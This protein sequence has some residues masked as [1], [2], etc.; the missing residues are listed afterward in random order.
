MKVFVNYKFLVLLGLFVMAL[1]SCDDE[2]TDLNI[3]PN[4]PVEVPAANL[5]TQAEYSLVN[6]L[7]G[8]GLN[9]E[10]SMLMVQHFAQTEYAEES[11]YTVDAN[12]FN[13]EWTTFYASV[14]NELKIASEII[15]ADA[16]VPPARKSNQLAIVDVLT[17]YAYHNLTD[18]Y[19]AAPF[20]EALNSLDFPNPSYD[21][22]ESIYNSILS[23][24]SNAISAM[25]ES[26][27]SFSSGDLI[28]DGDV[29]SWKK[30]AN[31]LLLRMAMR[32]VD[33]DQ[34]TASTYIQQASTG[35]L[36]GSNDENGMFVFSDEADIANPLFRDHVI[37]NRDDF[38][39]TDV[40]VDHLKA[41]SDPRLESFANVNN[42][43][44]Y[45]G[46]PYGLTDGESFSLQTTRSR[47]S[48]ELRTATAPGIIMDYAEVQFLLAE[49]YER[50][51]LSGDASAAYNEGVK[52][53]MNYW[54]F[55]DDAMISAYLEANPYN[56][57][58]WK[59]SIGTQKWL[60]FYM[61]GTQAWAEWRRLDYPVLVVPAAA[62][63]TTIPVRLPY[64]IDEEVRNGTALSAVTSDPNDIST[65]LWWDV[66]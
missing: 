43:G 28:Y 26:A 20:A 61:N 44:E 29:A 46:L 45:L 1:P 18:L 22:Q 63:N 35:G 57:A 14:L 33:V 41:T 15:E 34:G 9:A 11:R 51:I 5:V 65:K 36:I 39:V 10:W 16:N 40:L 56:A 50:G 8:R 6:L 66:N 24:M 7:W 17:A 4:N 31:S 62:T 30:L 60:A 49:A 58:N 37:G 32:I 23:M 13:G 64:P 19:G 27:G 2:L 48:T 25:D 54:G 59:E 21:S 52:A 3:D 12:D 38:A 47:P 55:T 42:E 53:S